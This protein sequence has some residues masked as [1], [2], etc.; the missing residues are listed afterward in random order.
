MYFVKNSTTGCSKQGIQE[1]CGWSNDKFDEG[2]QENLPSHC[3]SESEGEIEIGPEH[4]DE[5]LSIIER[6]LDDSEM[7]KISN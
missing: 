3:L 2:S 1:S 7:N 4:Q 5:I 6:P